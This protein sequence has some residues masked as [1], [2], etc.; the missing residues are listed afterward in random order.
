MLYGDIFL[1]VKGQLAR[2]V[3]LL[4]PFGDGSCFVVLGFFF[5]Q[6]GFYLWDSGCPGTQYINQGGLE[7]TELLQ[8][9]PPKL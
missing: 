3:S 9:L 4:P 1:K 6:I 2:I 5:P 8:P 7:F